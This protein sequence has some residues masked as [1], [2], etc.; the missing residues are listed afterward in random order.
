M[1]GSGIILRGWANDPI[2]Q[3]SKAVITFNSQRHAGPTTQLEAENIYIYIYISTGYRLLFP[4]L[5][6]SI[7]IYLYMYVCVCLSESLYD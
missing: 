4:C 1:L 7:R 5:H 3:Y 6:G 2:W